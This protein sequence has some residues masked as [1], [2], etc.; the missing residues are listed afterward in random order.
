MVSRRIMPVFETTIQVEQ[1]GAIWLDAFCVP[2]NEPARTACLRKMGEIYRHASLVIVV[3][4][5]SCLPAIKE[6]RTA[7][8]VSESAM[9]ALAAD[10]W[11]TRI[12][13]YQE[14]VNSNNVRF[15]C[16]GQG[17]V[18]ADGE[19]I[20]NHVGFAIHNYKKK[21]EYNGY[22]FQ[23]VHPRIDSL[24]SL[25]LDW[26]IAAYSERSAYQVLCNVA[27][28]D[29]RNQEDYFY[30]ITGAIGLSTPE[31]NG[32]VADHPAEFFMRVCEKKGDYS[33]I[34]TIGTRDSALGKSWRPVVSE[35]FLPVF[36]CSSW[37]EGQSADVCDGYIQLNNMVCMSAATLSAD[38]RSF[39]ME[40]L[41]DAINRDELQ[42]LSQRI[43]HRL[44]QADFT[45]TGD[46][47]ETENG[48]FFVQSAVLQAV[49]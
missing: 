38:T 20:L 27:H 19:E 8:E 34:Y 41:Q 14:M 39:L 25:V 17:N 22:K 35:R 46:S 13:T 29:C 21:M 28:R 16:E 10:N 6:I 24:E 5:K 37:G 33:F 12:W 44:R 36:A 45:G 18:W 31:M 4:S 40:W 23:S 43:L 15:V 3:L 30:A 7:G 1:T 42:D 11:V 26:R 32:M 48:Y 9:L 2:T 49:D 47:I